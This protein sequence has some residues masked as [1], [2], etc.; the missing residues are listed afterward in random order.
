MKDAGIRER[1]TEA[2]NQETN[3]NNN[4]YVRGLGYSGYVYIIKRGM[5]YIKGC[6]QKGV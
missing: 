6:R 2:G 3:N 4:L 5:F 1:T